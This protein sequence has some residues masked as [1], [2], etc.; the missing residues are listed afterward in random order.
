MQPRVLKPYIEK[1]LLLYPALALLG[2]RQVGKTTLAKSFGDLYFDLEQERDRLK[3][4][5]QWDSLTQG[6]TLLIL[7]EAQSW[8]Q[9]FPRIRGAI[10]ADSAA[11]G[12][13]LLL[14]SVSPFLMKEVSESLAGRLGLAELTPFLL[15]ELSFLSGPSAIQKLWLMG[16]YPRGGI[17]Q[18]PVTL[19]PLWQ[20]DY[21]DVLVHRDL[22]Q[23]GLAARPQVTA[24]FLS[25]LAGLH[26][27]Q[28]NASQVASALGLS[29]HTI[30]TYFDFLEGA[31]LVRRLP[32]FFANL[33]KRLT[34]TPKIYL[35]DSG[36]L[37]SLLRISSYEELL[38]HPLVGHSFEGFVIE[39]I[40]ST[41]RAND[42]DHEA[43]Y[44]RM[45]DGSCEADLI[46]L[47]KQDVWVVEIK[48]T[49]EPTP[50]HW[51]GLQKVAGLLHTDCMMLVSMTSTVDIQGTHVSTHVEGAVQ[52]LLMRYS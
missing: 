50:H 23:W 32:P 31:Y 49:S 25:L 20:K 42:I 12:R 3:L 8:P 43:F 22:P 51:S 4:D 47:L 28:W 37:H 48:L 29:Y 9:L 17:L 34:K 36:L 52:T 26:G 11:V 40:L 2:P 6:S 5:L 19:F 46:L 41:L 33:Q 24:R 27:Q 13:F 16:G 18:E 7:D 39:Q 21:L 1:R 35:R 10:D 30:N 38:S 14:G 45:S 15:S 44:F